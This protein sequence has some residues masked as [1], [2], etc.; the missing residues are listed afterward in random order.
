MTRVLTAS[1]FFLVVALTETQVGA[2]FL[3]VTVGGGNSQIVGGGCP[4]SVSALPA[5]PKKG[6]L[7]CPPGS[8][9]FPDCAC[10][11]GFSLANVFTTSVT[12]T[13]TTSTLTSFGA[14][15]PTF[16]NETTALTT[17]MSTTTLLS[18]ASNPSCT[19]KVEKL[20]RWNGER[21]W[22]DKCNPDMC[23]HTPQPAYSLPVSS[24][25]SPERMVF[26]QRAR[27]LCERGYFVEYYSKEVVASQ[28]NLP[29][30]YT[31]FPG[32]YC[33]NDRARN[34]RT[35]PLVDQAGCRRSCDAEPTCTA[36]EWTC[37]GSC[38]LLGECKERMPSTCGGTLV[39]KNMLDAVRLLALECTAD[40]IVQNLTGARCMPKCGDGLLVPTEHLPRELRLEQCDDGNVRSGDGCSANCRVEAD[41]ICTGGSLGGPDVCRKSEVNAHSTLWLVISGKRIPDIEELKL[42]TE[43][44]LSV[45]LSCPERDLEIFNVLSSFGKEESTVSKKTETSTTT[46]IPKTSTTTTSS[47]PESRFHSFRLEAQIDFKV[48]ISDPVGLS[49]DTIEGA[50]TTRGILLPKLMVAYTDHTTLADLY[51]NAPDIQAPRVGGDRAEG[52]IAHALPM[53]DLLIRWLAILGPVLFYLFLIGFVFPSVYWFIRVRRR[54]WRLMGRFEDLSPEFTGGW[55]FNICACMQDCFKLSSLICCLP[56]R[57]AD[58]WDAVGLMPYFVG[59]RKSFCC[60]L[61]YLGGCG[62]CAAT[63][64][65][66][67][68]SE[69]RDFFGFGDKVKGN[70]EL[71][72]WCCYVCCPLCCIIQ[73]ARHV[74]GALAVLPPPPRH[75]EARSM[76]RMEAG[77]DR[78]A[79]PGQNAMIEDGRH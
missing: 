10:Q 48:K 74:D 1:L 8:A 6:C 19:L 28:S 79:P 9:G 72:D 25:E 55:A 41:W 16:D 50:L 35:V 67:Q 61:M 69:L 39:V 22:L 43:V 33:T 47:T 5:C 32:T 68:R 26:P 58:T 30:T 34:L 70:L 53:M 45:A 77:E 59:V 56:S 63:I 52:N 27:F 49:I 7:P 51:V 38:I 2:Q 17:N 76:A 44:A 31:R 60:C 75:W 57:M 36:F 23:G 12:T 65:G 15:L 64:P 73:E 37:D 4:T 14:A 54:E 18:W 40:G 24:E 11:A 66:Q 13:R 42:A 78:I 20:L 3:N 71:S 46:K 62:L 29:W 21:G